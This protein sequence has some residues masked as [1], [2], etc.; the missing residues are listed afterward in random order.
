P[1]ELVVGPGELVWLKADAAHLAPA[2]AEGAVVAVAL[3]GGRDHRLEDRLFALR[4]ADLRNAAAEVAGAV[5]DLGRIDEVQGRGTPRALAARAV[6]SR[7]EPVGVADDGELL[8][9]I[10]RTADVHSQIL[11]TNVLE[12]KR[13][14]TPTIAAG[15]RPST[16]PVS[17]GNS[18]PGDAAIS[19]PTPAHR[20][21]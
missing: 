8:D 20:P 14:P 7:L 12:V 6:A 11:G 1:V 13:D 17:P 21:A 4:R 9:C 16:R 19:L 5:G 10:G 2:R 15:G 3:A 18:L